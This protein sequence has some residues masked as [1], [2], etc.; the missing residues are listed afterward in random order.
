MNQCTCSIACSACRPRE[1]KACQRRQQ[2]STIRRMCA[3]RMFVIVAIVAAL[4]TRSVRR[5]V[6]T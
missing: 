3:A 6:I 1:F 5:C 2:F 4:I